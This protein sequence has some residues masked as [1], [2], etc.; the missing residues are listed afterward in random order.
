MTLVIT[1]KQNRSVHFISDSSLNFGN[2]PAGDFG[3]KISRIPVKVLD[4]TDEKGN[5]QIIKELDLAFSFSGNAVAGTMTKDILY[6]IV[7]EIQQVPNI[8]KCGMDGISDIIFEVYKQVLKTIT[9]SIAHN[10]I[11]EINF[12]G[13]CT[14]A[15]TIRTFK[16]T[17]NTNQPSMTELF[18]GNNS[19]NLMGSGAPAAKVLLQNKLNI[20]SH[21]AIKIMKDVIAD[22]TETT[23][24]GNIQ[25]GKLVENIFTIYGVMDTTNNT[26]KYFRGG[27]DLNDKLMGKGDFPL[28]NF[29]LIEI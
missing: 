8:T 15:S 5:R 25:Y 14:S 12:A 28:S 9:T 18:T 1:W 4:A 2:S 22:P 20:T 13:Y 26:P 27:F 3:I 21:D 6:E 17:P 29:P 7:S 11:F 24:G 10:G 19:V 23:V 16:L